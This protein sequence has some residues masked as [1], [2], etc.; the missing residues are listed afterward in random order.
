METVIQ[1][2]SN[3]IHELSSLVRAWKPVKSHEFFSVRAS[4]KAVFQILL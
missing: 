4:F 3:I 1:V 2:Y